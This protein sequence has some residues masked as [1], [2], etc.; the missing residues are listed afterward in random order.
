MGV[1][2]TYLAENQ[3][4]TGAQKCTT[5]EERMAFCKKYLKEKGLVVKR[6]D[7]DDNPFEPP[8]WSPSHYTPNVTEVVSQCSI[9]QWMLRGRDPSEQSLWIREVRK[10]VGRGILTELI[11]ND[12]IKFHEERSMAEDRYWIKGILKV[13]R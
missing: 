13:T 2:D 8:V 4:L 12:Y 11:K 6:P 1:F 5:E 10:D 7:V 3:F 9:D